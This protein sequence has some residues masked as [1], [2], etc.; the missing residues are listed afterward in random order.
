MDWFTLVTL[1]I[2][3]YMTEKELIPQQHN[4]LDVK[5]GTV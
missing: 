1:M 5:N 4:T 2:L 3:Q